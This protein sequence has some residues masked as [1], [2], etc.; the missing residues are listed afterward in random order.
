LD[1]GA[2]LADSHRFGSNYRRGFDLRRGTSFDAIVVDLT[3]LHEL[4]E[5]PLCHPDSERSRVGYGK[6]VR[7][8]LSRMLNSATCLIQERLM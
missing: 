1:S 6:A 2:I 3:D 5:R 7:G 8:R 4:W